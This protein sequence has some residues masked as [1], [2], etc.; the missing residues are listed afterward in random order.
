ML[1]AAGGERFSL[2]ALPPLVLRLQCTA[3][4]FSHT[5][6]KRES[7][8]MALNI[9]EAGGEAESPKLGLEEFGSSLNFV[10]YEQS[11]IMHDS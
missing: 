4:L 10:I 8:I 5:G 9:P 3:S 1:S 6:N 7:Q 11:V 2:P